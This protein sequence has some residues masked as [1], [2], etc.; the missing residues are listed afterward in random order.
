MATIY[1]QDHPTSPGEPF[2][3]QEY[4]APCHSNGS[5]TLIL[6]PI[7]RHSQNILQSP[8]HA[9]SVTVWSTPPAASKARVSLVGNVTMLDAGLVAAS[10][11]QECYLQR[12][13]DA[14]WWLP[15]DPDAPHIAVWARFDP[16]SVYFVGG[17]GDKHYIGS[18][19]I[20][21]YQN[22]TGTLSQIELEQQPLQAA[23]SQE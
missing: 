2:A 8:S 20:D 15:E 3:L 11:I 17:F 23:E 16:H 1:P 4:Y 19:P 18:I 9:A 10:G 12:H 14:K 22:T 7:S 21:L 13:P 6:M 5:L